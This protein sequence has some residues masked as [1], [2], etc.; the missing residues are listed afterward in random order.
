MII[1]PDKNVIENNTTSGK[2]EEDKD[3]NIEND[4]DGMTIEQL[5]NQK[6]K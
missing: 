3:N 4:T 2:I 1:D 6:V 5:E